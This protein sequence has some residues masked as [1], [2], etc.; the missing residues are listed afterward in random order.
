MFEPTGQALLLRKTLFLLF[1]FLII[2]KMVQFNLISIEN[3]HFKH[4]LAKN[5]TKIVKNN[6][7]KIK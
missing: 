2:F 5:Y 3:S 1:L 7:K 4:M 6:T